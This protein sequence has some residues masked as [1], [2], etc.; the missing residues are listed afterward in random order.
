MK[1][2]FSSRVSYCESKKGISRSNHDDSPWG[3]L[4]II[5]KR[6][7]GIKVSQAKAAANSKQQA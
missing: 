6:N 4:A 5:K 2:G 1:T 3:I 7:G